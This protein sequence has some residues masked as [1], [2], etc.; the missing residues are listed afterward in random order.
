MAPTSDPRAGPVP[1][2]PAPALP[3]GRA[4]HRLRLSRQGRLPR[5]CFVG[6]TCMLVGCSPQTVLKP[7]MQGQQCAVGS[8]L[9]STPFVLTSSLA[10]PTHVKRSGHEE[11]SDESLAPVFTSAPDVMPVCARNAHHDQTNPCPHSLGRRRGASDPDADTGRAP[12]APRRPHGRREGLGEAATRTPLSVHPRLCSGRYGV[13]TQTV[14]MPHTTA[15]GPIPLN[16]QNGT[17]Y[18]F[19]VHI[20]YYEKKFR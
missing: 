8:G 6:L 14:T 11:V 19:Y 12:P 7:P 2:S 3:T 15:E 10:E 18:V 13:C 20:F 1:A 4:E 17:C 16:A 9:E 5:F